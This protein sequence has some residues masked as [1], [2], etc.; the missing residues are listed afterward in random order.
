MTL[1]PV[2]IALT[3]DGER[4]ARTLQVALPGSEVHGLEHRTDAPDVP[5]AETVKHIATLYRSGRSIVGVC[6][7]GILVRAVAETLSD[8]YA[9]PPLIAVS[10][11]GE[12]VVP[13][14]G[15]HRGA[16]LL[17]TQIGKALG[18]QAAVTTAGDVAF[19][20][21]LDDPGTGWAVPDASVAKPV[22]AALL[23]GEAVR[24]DNQYGLPLPKWLG[25]LPQSDTASQTIV[26]SDLASHPADGAFQIVPKTL[27]L[28]VGCE[29]GAPDEE[30]LTL[31]MKCLTNAGVHPAAIACVVSLDLKADESA[32]LALA[33]TLGVPVRLF[34]A[35]TLEAETPRLANPSDV[36]FNEVGCHGVAEGAALAAV[37]P[38]GEL[39]LPKQKTARATCAIARA[40][41][42][43][44]P[45]TIGRARGRLSIVGIGPGQESWRTPEVTSW[46][47]GCEDVVGY[48][49]YLDLLGDLI[50]G[51]N[52]HMSELSEE[53][54]RVRRSLELAAEGR[55]VALVSSGDAGIYAMAALAFEVLDRDDSPA[56]NRVEIRVS[57][58]ISAVQAAAARIGAP[59]G[60]DFALISLS[61]LL[62]PWEVI[63]K[64]IEAVADGDF[65][66]A[67]YNPVSKRRRT[68]LARA[69]EILLS[70]R[71]AGTPVV[72]GRNLGRPQENVRVVTLGTLTVDEVDML[73][74]VLIGSSSSKKIERGER[75]WV[76]TPRGYAAKI[77]ANN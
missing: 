31:A 28:G 21:A 12:A 18:I 34:D 47:A 13:I 56:F 60:H 45:S 25:S 58:G 6:A 69:R 3:I 20:S 59:L 40:P 23:A 36:V 42:P 26:V 27:A 74:L 1:A 16:N 54:A 4:L 9:E 29:R 61:D 14:L 77:D 11:T 51:K 17:A 7:S 30:L 15:G 70:K 75:T 73:T 55:D 8:K 46:L 41:Q 67:F 65:T 64:R 22:A 38:D 76:Y 68:Q 49:L 50:S 33:A 62:T 24:I 53:E 39:V 63:E 5:F 37:G 48:G 44:E 19:G 43:L 2:I 10:Q 35:K 32:V 66:V 52:R 71:P 72:L 57:P